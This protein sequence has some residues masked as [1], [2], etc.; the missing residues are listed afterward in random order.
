MTLNPCGPR[1]LRGIRGCLLSGSLILLASLGQ[2]S[3]QTWDRKAAEKALVEARGQREEI[4]RASSPSRQSYLDCAEKYRLVYLSDP[5][6][7]GVDDAIFEEGTLYAE[8]GNRFKILADYQKSA[9]LLEFL[10]SDYDS[11]PYLPDALLNLG[12]LYAGPLGD[13]EAA[14]DCF[15]KLRTEY[16]KSSA[17]MQ[18]AG[19]KGL[20]GNMQRKSSVQSPVSAPSRSASV[21]NI[22]HWTTRDHTRVEIDMEGVAT[23]RKTRISDP[24]RIFF[25]ISNARLS[26]DLGNRK[27]PVGDDFVKQVRVAQHQEDVV[28]VVLD[29]ARAADFSVS[30]LHAPFRIVIDIYG[31]RGAEAVARRQPAPEPREPAAATPRADQPVPQAKA[32]VTQ[33]KAPA[34]PVETAPLVRR[35][36]TKGSSTTAPSAAEASQSSGMPAGKSSSVPKE[37][38]PIPSTGAAKPDQAAPSGTPELKSGIGESG[39]APRG[40]APETVKP[41]SEKASVQPGTTAAGGPAGSRTAVA[42]AVPAPAAAQASPLKGKP[43]AATTPSTPT[44]AASSKPADIPPPPVT[45]R[46][47]APPPK[48]AEL[49]SMGN[50]T[51]TR[52]LGLKIGR[53]VLDPG[54]GGYDTGTIGPGGLLE[55]DLVLAV[56]RQLR[57]LLS[58]KLGA[59]VVLTRNDDSFVSLEERT[60][61]ANRHE[62]D[63]FISIHANSSNIRTLSGVETYYLDFARSASEREVAA[64]ENATT[65]KNVRD[66]ETLIKKIAQADK[67]AESREL[68]AMIQKKLYS[69]AQRLFPSARNRGVRRA[70][71]VVLIGANMPSVLAEVAFLSNPRDEVVLKKLSSRERLAMALYSGIESYMKTL[72]SVAVQNHSGS[73]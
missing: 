3:A 66:L 27:I 17:T 14:E 39:A 64:R 30:E 10:I 37:A 16:R 36:E 65:D 38:A 54:H 44:G 40:A 72:G 49:T 67:S 28:R 11:S 48:A 31:P 12:N 22:R 35:G 71:F 24:D 26:Q 1:F 19:Q 56:A 4:A 25:D 9:R 20:A 57:N 15:R 52:I 18:L 29:L 5:H 8:M 34:P 7:S 21:Q 73:N 47:A 70:P 13:R 53:I 69:G 61:I 46:D 55:K 60:E 42:L 51:L 41:G 58:D 68:A 43:G 62:A 50:R 45:G 32:A 2:G 63:L 33:A 23:Y 59:D 6:F